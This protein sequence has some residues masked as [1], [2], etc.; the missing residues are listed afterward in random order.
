MVD[1]LGFFTSNYKDPNTSVGCLGGELFSRIIENKLGEIFSPVNEYYSTN[2]YIDYR[3]IYIKNIARKQGIVVSSPSISIDHMYLRKQEIFKTQDLYRVRI[4]LFAP[5]SYASVNY[6]HPKIFT[7]GQF[8]GENKYIG[9][10]TIDNKNPRYYGRSIFLDSV[11]LRTNEYFPVIL[12]RVINGPVPF[13]K[14]FSFKLTAKYTTT[15]E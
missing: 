11:V 3:V 6:I 10:L 1:T 15:L 9:D 8:I 7:S 4:N 5:I 14:N 12:E 13:V 2:K